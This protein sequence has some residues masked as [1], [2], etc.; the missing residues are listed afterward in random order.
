M[1][2]LSLISL[3]KTA[4]LLLHLQKARTGRER[5]REREQEEPVELR[6]DSA[7][8]QKNQKPLLLLHGAIP[9]ELNR[10]FH[11]FFV[12]FFI[13]GKQLVAFYDIGCEQ[14]GGRV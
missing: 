10:F 6:M 12:S 7:T 1:N 8:E 11:T 2:I 9:P 4:S 3:V 13:N 5:E 14:G